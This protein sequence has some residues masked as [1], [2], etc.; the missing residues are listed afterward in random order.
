MILIL[1]F[2]GVNVKNIFILIILTSVLSGCSSIYTLGSDFDKELSSPDMCPKDCTV[3]RIYSGISLDMC[4]L[5]SDEPGQGGAI[6]FWDLPFSAIVDTVVL[7]Y[8]IYKQVSDG[9]SVSQPL[10]AESLC[11]S[12]MPPFK[13]DAEHSK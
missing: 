8:T 12:G 7:P 13:S 3:H 1:M 2:K 11:K 10:G 4:I 9:G 5:R 6:A